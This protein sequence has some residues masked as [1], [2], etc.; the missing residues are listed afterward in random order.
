MFEELWLIREGICLYYDKWTETPLTLDPNL[1][2]AFMSALKTFQE[3]SFPNQSIK[4][5][6]LFNTRLTYL[7]AKFFY[8]VVREPVEKPVD[9]TYQ[10][11]RN[12]AEEIEKL[13]EERDE[14]KFLK[15]N[16]SSNPLEKYGT[17]IA[18]VIA[19]ILEVEEIAENQLKSFDF[20][21]MTYLAREIRDLILTI[22]PYGVLVNIARSNKNQWFYDTIMSDSNIEPNIF[23]HVSYRDIVHYMNDFLTQTEK[24]FKVY[25][26]KPIDEK[27]EKARKDLITFLAINSQII[28]RFG[29]FE[30]ILSKFVL[31]F[32]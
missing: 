9:R 7:N 8:L 26:V 25:E 6:D 3:S 24:N 27:L 11:L 4:N 10:Q 18:P 17:I 12:I 5:V 22:A 13:I 31:L 30:N 14:L 19:D 23:T 21:T 1:F 20:I 2:S 16:I 32:K 28:S 29:L 15:S